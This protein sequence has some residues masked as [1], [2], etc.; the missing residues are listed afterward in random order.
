LSAA[1]YSLVTTPRN[2]FTSIEGIVY[3]KQT[4]SI[5]IGQ[6]DLVKRGEIKVYRGISRFTRS[7]VIVT[8]GKHIPL[9]AVI[10]ATGYTHSLE[11]FLPSEL[12]RII[13][14]VVSS[15]FYVPT[16][17][18]TLLRLH[19]FVLIRTVSETDRSYESSPHPLFWTRNSFSG[20]PL[21]DWVPR[22]CRTVV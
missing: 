5:D 8:E 16:P 6:W 12:V 2:D 3:G 1:S 13:I 17:E 19:Y 20:K 18:I 10:F 15:I 4:P 22:Y 14:I 9:D 21:V 7:G 11:T